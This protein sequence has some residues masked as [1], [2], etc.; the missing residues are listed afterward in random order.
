M[1]VLAVCLAGWLLI[2]PAIHS[3]RV[4]ARLSACQGNLQRL[5]VALTGYSQAHSGYFPVVPARGRLA[6]AG[7][8]APTL[9][10]SGFLTEARAVICP[11]SKLGQ[12]AAFHVPSLEELESAPEAE[13][14]KLQCAMG[15]SYGYNLG[16]VQDGVYHG[17]KNLGRP[18]F[19]IAADAPS[20]DRPDH[21]SATTAHAAR[22][23]C[24]RTGT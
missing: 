24:S 12:S 13:L 8:Y 23:S 22:T 18:Y 17:T 16:Y 10:R 11:S 6:V 19:A 4:S 1:V 15:G 3:S 2:V 20:A 5:G 7:I 14:A 9:L 21:Q